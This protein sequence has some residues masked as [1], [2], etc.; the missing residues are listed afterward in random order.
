MSSARLSF[1]YPEKLKTKLQALAKKDNRSVSSY[2]Q[3]V[4][5]RHIKDNYKTPPRKKKITAKKD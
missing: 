4:L 3:D 5:I 2:I 1:S